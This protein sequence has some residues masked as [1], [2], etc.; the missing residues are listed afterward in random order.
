MV[1]DVALHPHSLLEQLLPLSTLLLPQG[2][3]QG[4]ETSFNMA[5][6]YR[7]SGHR[8][9]DGGERRRGGKM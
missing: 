4:I 6:E 3:F 7:F 8:Q 1:T 5:C 2:A 9:E